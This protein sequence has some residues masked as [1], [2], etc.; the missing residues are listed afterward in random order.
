MNPQPQAGVAG[1]GL[2]QAARRVVVKVGSAVLAPSRG[3]DR[4][5]VAGLAQELARIRGGGRQVVLVSSGAVAA[6]LSRVPQEGAGRTI[7]EKQALAAI[8]QGLLMREYEEAFAGLGV[9]VAQILLTR[10]GLVPRH[11]YLNARNTLQTLLQWG[12]LPI[13][14]ENDTVATEELQFTDNDALAV[15]VTNLVDGD[16]LICLSDIDGLYT[17]DPREDPSARRLSQVEEVDESVLAMASIRPGRAG[18][19]GMRSKLQAARMVTA[20]GVPMVVAAGREPGV[21]TRLFEG[22]ELGTIFLPRRPRIR[23]RKGWIVFALERKGSITIDSGAVEALRHGNGSLLAVG[24]KGVEGEFY[25]GDCVVCRDESG[26][27]VAVGICNYSSTELACIAGLQSGQ[28]CRVIDRD[29]K[30]EVIHRDNLVI[31]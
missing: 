9:Q 2:V 3:L 6:G 28:I 4:R 19:G 23:G 31:L 29:V 13:V 25:A 27:E 5:M 17:A 1:R 21:L 7:P 10:D 24:V 15:L 18:R 12:V 22:E 30:E 14:N 11:R 26:A 20:C 8:G 16:L